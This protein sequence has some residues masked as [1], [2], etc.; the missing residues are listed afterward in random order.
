MTY[1]KQVMIAV[2]INTAVVDFNGKTVLMS[3]DE[4]QPLMLILTA[5]VACFSR[6]LF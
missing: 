5:K 4:F 6:Q 2:K 1:S 3:F